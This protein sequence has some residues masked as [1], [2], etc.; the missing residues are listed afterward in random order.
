MKFSIITI[1]YN[2]AHLIEE[3]IASVLKQT[4]QNWEMI[5]V[6]DGSTDNTEAVISKYIEKYGKK[7]C[8]IKCERIGKPSTL[9][10]I[11]IKNATG[12][13]I[14]ILD[15]DDLWLDTKLEE[16][17]TIFS[18]KKEV[19]FVF[20]NLQHFSE[21]GKLKP[22]YYKYPNSFYRSI[23][24]ELLRG[25]ILAFPVFSMRRELVNEMGPID[26]DVMEGQQEYYLKAAA[27]YDIYYLNKPLTL[28]R[29]H[30]QN[31]T[32]NFDLIHT[33]DALITFDKLIEA[34]LLTKKQYNMA[35]NL[36]N[37]KITKYYF[38]ENEYSKGMKYLNFI[39]IKWYV[40]SKILKFMN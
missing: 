5:I 27:L 8:Y 23:I 33:T 40:K 4:C 17:N 16:M 14:S 24:D 26:E 10:N 6:D 20:H 18:Q 21:I 13:I 2:R 34:N 31:L 36:I 38:E 22:A 39:F 37:F 12:N 35:S 11:A 29:R 25:D 9:R 32:K 19:K 7:F 30:E 1:T 28:M 3:T 15:S